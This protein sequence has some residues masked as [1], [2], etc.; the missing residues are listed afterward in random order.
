MDQKFKTYAVDCNNYGDGCASLG[1]ELAKEK[2]AELGC[3]IDPKAA[4]QLVRNSFVDDIGGGGT[5]EEVLR[6]RGSKNSLGEY[7]GTIPKIL[8]KG[9]L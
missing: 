9:G 8:A 5:K 2:T 1:L 3:D 7:T 6:M 4:D